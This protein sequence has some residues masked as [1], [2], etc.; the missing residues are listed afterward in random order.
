MEGLLQSPCPRRSQFAGQQGVELFA[1]KP[2][3][4]MTSDLVREGIL[5]LSVS[6]IVAKDP[7]EMEW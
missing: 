6:T 4:T 3:H 1:G 5:S 7:A 2:T